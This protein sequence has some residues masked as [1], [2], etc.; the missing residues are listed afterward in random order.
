L[1]GIGNPRAWI[2]KN[3]DRTAV[4]RVMVSSGSARNQVSQSLVVESAYCVECPD[5]AER[6]LFMNM[7]ASAPGCQQ[8]LDA[9]HVRM[10]D[11]ISA[12]FLEIVQNRLVEPAPVA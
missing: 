4:K 11:A 5:S 3:I 9:F 1:K 2:E 8:F 10:R 7:D 6:L 12:Q